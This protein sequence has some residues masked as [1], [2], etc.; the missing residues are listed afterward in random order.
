MGPETQVH[1]A[2]R[3]AD[4]SFGKTQRATSLPTC[5]ESSGQLSGPNMPRSDSRHSEKC[6]PCPC[7]SRRWQPPMGGIPPWQRFHQQFS[8]ASS[9]CGGHRWS[10]RL[11]DENRLNLAQKVK[12]QSVSGEDAT[13]PWVSWCGRRWGWRQNIGMCLGFRRK[14]SGSDEI[15][16]NSHTGR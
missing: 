13:W 15:R 7:F 6:S 9:W 4:S 8:S 2:I 1:K 11:P 10:P 3:L 5:Q 16:G 14:K 12:A